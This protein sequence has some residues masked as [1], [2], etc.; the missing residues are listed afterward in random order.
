MHDAYL[1]N[2]TDFGFDVLAKHES[3]S[4]L[5]V[6]KNATEGCWRQLCSHANNCEPLVKKWLDDQE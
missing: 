1:D 2:D 5:K 3:K 6:K 4:P